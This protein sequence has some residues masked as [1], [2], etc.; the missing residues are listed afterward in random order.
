MLNVGL[1]KQGEIV[2][3]NEAFPVAGSTDTNIHE[4]TVQL[5]NGPVIRAS[6][7]PIPFPHN[8]PRYLFVTAE[9][10][11]AGGPHEVTVKAFYWADEQRLR[12]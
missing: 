7:T 12:P 1:P 2:G 9:T 10:T 5:D 11:D 4:V 6:V 3:I 8:P